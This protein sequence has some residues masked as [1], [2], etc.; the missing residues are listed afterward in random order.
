FNV[1]AAA[2]DGRTHVAVSR[3]GTAVASLR[4]EVV[5]VGQSQ[6]QVVQLHYARIAPGGNWSAGASFE[7]AITL[8]TVAAVTPVGLAMGERG[9]RVAVL[10][11]DGGNFALRGWTASPSSLDNALEIRQPGTPRAL[12]ASGDLSRIVVA[13]QFA[14]DNL[15]QGGAHLF[16]FAQA[17]PLASYF[18]TSGNM[19]DIVGA[20]LS[21]DGRTLALGGGAGQLF[22][23]H[24]A[25]DRLDAPATLPLAS[26]GLANLTLS[27]DGARLAA[28]VGTAVSMVD[29]QAAPTLLWNAT[30]PGQA[31]SGLAMNRTGGL[32][33]VATSG[34]GGGVRAY[35]DV[36]ATP[37]WTIP[38]DTRAVALNA[39]GSRVAYAG[40]FVGAGG[41]LR[42]A[43]SGAG[44]PRA[45]TMELAAGGK[46]APTQIVTIPGT[47]TVTVNLK[48]DGAGLE[49]VVF[50]DTASEVTVEAN[51]SIV[52][53]RP[54][55]TVRV[56]LIVNVTQPLVGQRVFNV[57]ARS[58]TSKVVDNVT[59]SVVPR[60][61]LD[62]KLSLNVT[63]VLA[64]PGQ[65]SEF[66]ITI[67]NN[68]TGDAPVVLNA[69]QTVTMGRPWDV[70]L[71]EEELIALR[72][73][74]TSVK[75]TVTPPADALNG[76]AAF[77]TLRLQGQDIFDTSRVSFRINPELK[78]EVNA[79]GVTKLIEPGRRAFYNVTVTNIGSLP[80]E[81]DVFY[82]ITASDNRNWGV[83]MATAAV[84]LDP[85]AHRVFPVTIVAPADALPNERVAVRVVA[86]S[87]P[88]LVNETVV[89]GN[90]T[91]FGVAIEPKIT[92][93]STPNNGI[94][95]ATPLAA[96]AVLLLAALLPRRR[97]P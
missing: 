58:L 42:S 48:N 68:G 41:T 5:I 71:T 2:P 3:D 44:I 61:T 88:E 14:R 82:T 73:T 39:E 52:D 8:G 32:L 96:I 21:R 12:A 13:G 91:L 40:N 63:D 43:I 4:R 62:V 75:V 66:L 65:P 30:V 54:G 38:G 28:A 55:A 19:T 57:T 10:L 17:S 59:L 89:E 80:R 95:F 78:V 85:N 15:T 87:I 46:V 1:N 90:V 45:L 9:D 74:S 18:D 25:R 26:A 64:Q 22:L 93:T 16:Q 23:F 37:L 20:A 47:T 72:G 97:R 77:I 36:D 76:T 33:A 49:R 35:T 83:D 7:R 51:R 94:P 81:F 79:T 92:T 34:N 11:A 50:E 24:G 56:D 84:R 67:V 29:A 53:V 60:P 70:S 69:T 6:Q 86:R 31:I 27:E